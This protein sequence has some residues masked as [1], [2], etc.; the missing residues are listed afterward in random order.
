MTTTPETNFPEITIAHQ[1]LRPWMKASVIAISERIRE[2]KNKRKKPADL[3][4]DAPWSGHVS[5]LDSLRDD[6]RI[7]NI[8]YGLVRGH[9]YEQI[10]QKTHPE[11]GL[12]R[13]YLV[14]RV[15]ELL[16]M[17]TKLY[18]AV[19]P[20]LGLTPEQVAVQAGHAVAQFM[21]DNTPSPWING[22]LMYIDMP[23][24]FGSA[25]GD[26]EA[27]L[28]RLEAEDPTGRW[29]WFNEPDV[30]NKPTAVA[31]WSPNGERELRLHRA[32]RMKLSQDAPV[33]PKNEPL[34]AVNQP[35]MMARLMGR[36]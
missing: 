25:S 8:A 30:D 12:A 35:S 19:N 1:R 14:S 36:A 5:G 10:E 3:T 11:H 34:V 29:S 20:H 18:V 23:S 22:T 31:I 32:P 28:L 33:L 26:H 21:V 4:K 15:K 2:L 27:S 7:L 13:S 6:A 16:D 9:K 17:Q 24:L